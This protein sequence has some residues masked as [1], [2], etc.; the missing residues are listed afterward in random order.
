[1]TCFKTMSEPLASV[2]FKH[3]VKVVP[4]LALKVF[5]EWKVKSTDY[6]L[7]LDGGVLSDIAQAKNSRSAKNLSSLAEESKANQVGWLV[8]QSKGVIGTLQ[9]INPL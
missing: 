1:M 4:T 3:A 7:V 5:W 8:S 9:L 6:Y 2:K